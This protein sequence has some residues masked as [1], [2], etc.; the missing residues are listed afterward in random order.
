MFITVLCE[1]EVQ[2]CRFIITSLPIS[3][4]TVDQ[5]DLVFTSVCTAIKAHKHTKIQLRSCC[6]QVTLQLFSPDYRL[7]SYLP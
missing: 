5:R 3:S 4:P 1:R 7:L 6:F 2:S